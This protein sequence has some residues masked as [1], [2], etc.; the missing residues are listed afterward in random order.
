M[1]ATLK[2]Y[3]DCGG[4]DGA[5]GTNQNTDG[6]GPPNI[7]FKQA[8]DTAID[9][10]DAMPIPAAGTNYSRWKQIYLRCSAA[11]VTSVSN[12]KFYTDGGGFGAGITLRVSTS[13]PT[14]NSGSDA[15]YEVAEVNNAMLTDHGGVAAVADAFGYNVGAP[16]AGPS[17]SEAGAIINAIGETTNYLV[18]QL[19]VTNAAS[20]GNLADET[21]TFQYDEI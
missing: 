2:V 14:K 17:I 21:L 13:F 11:P 20:S 15:G 16:L 19:E 7:R 4:A 8:D 12:V 10:A 9:L 18:L 5:P 3:F 1:A 6:L